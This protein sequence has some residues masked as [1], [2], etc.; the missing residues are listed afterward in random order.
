MK[1]T[2]QNKETKNFNNRA[3]G[4]AVIKSLCSNYNA[5]FS[6]QPRT[7][8]SGRVY[9]TDKA[10]KYTVRNFLE[11]EKRD[12]RVFLF[13]RLKQDEQNPYTL[14][15]AYNS[16]FDGE[17]ETENRNEIMSK[18][19]SAIDVRLFGCTFAPKGKSVKDKNISIH[20]TT[21]INHGI[22]IWIK[23]INSF[24]EQIMSPFRNPTDKKNSKEDND[25]T[26]N[27]KS[28]TTLGRQFRLEEGHY[29]HHFS[30]NPQNLKDMEEA[31]KLT[32]NDIVLLKE[33][34][35]KGAT[36]Y[37]SASKAGVENEILFFVTL[38]ENS[39]LV[40]P[41]F[42]ELVKMKENEND[43]RIFDLSKVTHELSK[44]TEEIKSCEIYFNEN[45]VAVEN[46]PSNCQIF[47]LNK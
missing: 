32:Q 11:K 4:F 25:D 29:V 20:G 44:Y 23:G 15:E 37:D 16:F 45:L 30:V 9:A 21:Q 3:Y 28:A 46:L 12:E 1:M 42:T 19:L 39:T 36:Y 5:D 17:V 8:P 13:K 18:L 10:L 27:E 33:A 22:N 26:E 47:D 35:C 7:L 41:N 6:G 34:L 14:A 40:L 2:K 24:S 38:K 31:H 43:K